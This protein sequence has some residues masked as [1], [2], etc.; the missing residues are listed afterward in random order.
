MH[1]AVDV[2]RRIRKERK[3]FTQRGNALHR[4]GKIERIV[5]RLVLNRVDTDKIYNRRI[6]HEPLK[7][8]Y[9][10]AQ[11][12]KGAHPGSPRCRHD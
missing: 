10:D 8:V 1:A 5:F 12:P 9:R 2:P 3:T 7:V 6:Q 11:R 4:N